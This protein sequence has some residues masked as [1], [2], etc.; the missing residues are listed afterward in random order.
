MIFRE[1][2]FWRRLAGSIVMA[3]GAALIVLAR[4]SN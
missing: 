4:T 3:A 2:G 1:Q